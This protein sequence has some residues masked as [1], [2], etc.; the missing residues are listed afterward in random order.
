MAVLAGLAAAVHQR[1]RRSRQRD[2]LLEEERARALDALSL[3]AS[4]LRVGRT[5]S[6][7]LVAAAD[8]AVGV[9]SSTLRTAG[10]AARLGGDVVA[11]LRA[12][13]SAVATTLHA[14]AACW[15]VCSDAGSGLATAVERLA[16]GL[17]AAEAQRRAVLAELAGPR[18]TAQLLAVLPLGGIGLAGAL[19]AHPLHV[20][21]GTPVG[22]ACLLAGGT[23]DALGIAWTRRLTRSALP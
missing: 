21:L 10:A 12:D 14:L 19:G 20:L 18:A 3:L 1:V 7:A 5:P 23:L 4:D 6:E 16:E 22:L 8:V 9:S 11:V 2:A 15:Q 13:T 17:R